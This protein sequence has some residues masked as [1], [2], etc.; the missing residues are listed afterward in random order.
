V[1]STP[2]A[3]RRFVLLV[4]GL[5]LVCVGVLAACSDYAS[6]HRHLPAALAL[7]ALVVVGELRPILVPRTDATE[8]LT[9]S[10]GFALALVLVGALWM[11]VLVMCLAVLIEDTRTGKAGIKVAYNVAQSALILT[12]AGLVF[13][14]MTG[15]SVLRQ[16]HPLMLPR[17]LPAALVA[18]FTFWLV[19]MVLSGTVTALAMG[20]PVL[21]GLVVDLRFQLATAGL[22]LTFAPVIAVTVELTVWLLP[23]L[24]LPMG[25]IYVSAQLAA[26]REAEALHDG[27]TGL[28][29]R[30]LFSLRVRRLCEDQQPGSAVVAAVMLLDLDHFKEINDTLGHHVGDQLLRAVAE[31]LRDSVRPDDTVARLGG[32]EFAVLAT[33]LA[34][35][36][37]AVAVGERVLAALA[38]PFTVDGVRLDVEASLGVAL[39]PE[40]GDGIDLLLR[41]ADIALYAAKVERSCVRL[42]DPDED[43]HTLERLALATD[44][45]AGLERNELFLHYQPQL[46]LRDGRVLGFEALVRWRHPQHGVLMPDDFLPV[47]ENTGL[48]GPLTLE[49]LDL[50]LSAAASWRASG[51]DVGVAVNLS[52]RHL[53]DLS[54]PQQVRE[55]LAAHG[56]PASALSLEVTETLIMTDPGRSVGVL[57]LL[58]ELGVGLAVDDF[59]T[60]YSSLAYLR[61]LQVDELKIDK[62]FVLPLSRDDHDAVIV[63]STIELGHNLGLRLVAEGVEDRTTLDLLRSWGCDTAQGYHISRPMPSDAVLPWLAEYDASRFLPLAPAA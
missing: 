9:L 25:A 44:L 42:Y 11:A 49:V 4:C 47:V 45:R 22:L 35:G 28:P 50:A 52:V 48:I 56:L 63:R 2:A 55:R 23:L 29:N 62:S 58:R 7:G 30:T 57:A 53:T 3:L 36:A 19:N 6:W 51:H 14:A 8:E 1:S 34:S 43:P 21:R 16:L 12:A 46:D 59:G 60:G 27:L 17:E 32:D 39:L 24:V 13:G 61:R 33:D 31:R 5:A 40:H 41:K 10:T 26:R 20:E 15:Q 37:D 18:G 38:E 54:L